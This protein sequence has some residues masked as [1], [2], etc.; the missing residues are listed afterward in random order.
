MEEISVL[1]KSYIAHPAGAA[2]LVI[3][4]LWFL[5]N[6]QRRWLAELESDHEFHLSRSGRKEEYLRYNAQLTKRLLYFVHAIFLLAVGAL[7]WSL[8]ML[9]ANQ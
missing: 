7:I 6:E 4:M 9:I 8:M 2:F 3:I 1:L 5:N